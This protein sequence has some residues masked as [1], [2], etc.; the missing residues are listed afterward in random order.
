MVGRQNDPRLRSLPP[1]G[2]GKFVEKRG[3]ET[4]TEKVQRKSSAISR[5]YMI[6][7]AGDGI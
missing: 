5:S 4:N 7:G 3:R 6:T 1:G 2:T